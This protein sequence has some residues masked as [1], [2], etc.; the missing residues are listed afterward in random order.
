MLRE[1]PIMPMRARLWPVLF[2][3]VAGVFLIPPFPAAGASV[4]GI[5]N[6]IDDPNWP[7][8]ES[9]AT[10]ALEL[11]HIYW[12]RTFPVAF[13]STWIPLDYAAT[14]KRAIASATTLF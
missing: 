9:D 14:T 1:E 3:V 5:G 4:R 2:G 6:H 13:G 11:L 12:S 8:L 10:G 7:E